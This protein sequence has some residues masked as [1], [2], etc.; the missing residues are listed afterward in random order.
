M[1]PQH[2]GLLVGLLL[3]AAITLLVMGRPPS[4]GP[5]VRG[6]Q[7]VTALGEAE[8]RVKA[9]QAVISFG[10]ASRGASATEAEAL[11]LAFLKEIRSVVVAAGGD[12]NSIEILDRTLTE[13]LAENGVD[14]SGFE[15]RS[16]LRVL[17][18]NAARVQSVVDAGLAAGA[19]SLEGIVYS[20]DNPETAKQAA[21]KQAL[22]NARQR[23]VVLVRQQGES[24]GSLV[25][26]E[27]LE[28]EV[29]A[30]SSPGGVIFRAKVQ[31]TYRF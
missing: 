26:L 11:N 22:D 27:L 4:G 7:T 23:A 19:T 5:G 15:A 10:V 29:S 2:F 16:T 3:L 18:R 12:G 9:D 8:V 30:D 24:L 6:D 17:V 13:R 28:E 20:P 14:V 1:K 25:G 21:M 31:A